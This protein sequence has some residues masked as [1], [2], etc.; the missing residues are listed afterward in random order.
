MFLLKF[1]SFINDINFENFRFSFITMSFFSS[2]YLYTSGSRG[3]TGEIY[4]AFRRHTNSLY[5]LQSK[6]NQAIDEWSSGLINEIRE[7]A[8]K[9]KLI[10]Q[11]AHKL[12]QKHLDDMRDQ[13]LE[14]NSIYEQKRNTEEI[15]RLLEKC[16]TLEVEL[17]NLTFPSINKEFIEVTVVEPSEQTDQKELNSRKTSDDKF[18]DRSMGRDDIGSIHD[19]NLNL[20][21]SYSKST[22]LASDRIK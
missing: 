3:S 14:I 20:S 10:V 9:Q 13:F 19:G 12:H 18:E 17:V 15:E 1:S 22:A 11:E 16:K 4:D 5:D 7:H 6:A 21:S 2:S 8:F